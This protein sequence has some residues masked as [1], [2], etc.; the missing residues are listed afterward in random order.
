LWYV[1]W[2]LPASGFIPLRHLRAERYLYPASWGVLMILTAAIFA[3]TRRPR[4]RRRVQGLLFVLAVALSTYTAME[5][6]TWHGD[7]ELFSRAVN[8]DP[9]YIEG[10]LALAHW[11]LQQAE[12][13]QAARQSATAINQAADKNFSGYWSPFI[14]HTNYG[15]ALY[16]LRDYAAADREF[17]RAVQIQPDI[18][19]AHYHRGL[20]ALG[21][22]RPSLAEKHLERALE[23][24]PDDLLAIGNLA[25]ARLQQGDA[26]AC[27]DLLS[28]LV[29]QDPE[30]LINRRNYATAL[31]LL[32]E[33]PAAVEH[34]EAVVA[35]DPNAP[36]D[37]AKLAWALA[38][39]GRLREAILQFEKAHKAA[40]GHPTVRYVQGLLEQ[41]RKDAR[42][43]RQK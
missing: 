43:G 19:T 24:R 41:A 40:P 31:L 11:H 5:N 7:K 20:S 28:P 33:F 9:G 32:R 12:Y 1:V 26:Q 25:Y 8:R 4:T 36:I 34:F 18:A 35:R 10:R 6:L 16:Y 2:L 39:A 17:L 37:R 14:A 29:A 3:N 23:L 42:K 15:L 13:E 21:L 22:N 38:G 30:E 27:A